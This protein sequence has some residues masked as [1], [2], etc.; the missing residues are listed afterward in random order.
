MKNKTKAAQR[1]SQTSGPELLPHP[2][3]PP[4]PQHLLVDGDRIHYPNFA[5]S[6]VVNC[7]CCQGTKQEFLPV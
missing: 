3:Q 4:Q 7:W 1:S 2:G 5:Q 6:R